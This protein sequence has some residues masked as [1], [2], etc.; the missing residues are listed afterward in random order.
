MRRRSLPRPILTASSY[1]VIPAPGFRPE[2]RWSHA[3][4]EARAFPGRSSARMRST[5]TA[6]PTLEGLE[7]RLLLYSTLGGEWTYG[8]R[9]TYSFM[10]DGTNI[11]GTPSALFQTLNAKYATASWQQQLEQ[12]ATLWEGATNLN[13]ALV[14]DGGQAVGTSGNQQ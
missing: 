4:L 5:R 11:G 9:I 1:P 12:A 8:S 14:S 13:L 2:T 10:P 6:H 3:M 7:D